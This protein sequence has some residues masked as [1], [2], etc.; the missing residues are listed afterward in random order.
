MRKTKIVC[1]LG[2]ATEKE[3]TI[4]QMML[5]GMNV[6]RLNFSHGTEEQQKKYADTVKKLRKELDL[7]VALMLDTKGPEIRT[8]DFAAPVVLETGSRYT[9]TTRTVPGSKTV[10]S[11][12]FPRLPAEVSRGTRILID[13]GLIELKVE[14]IS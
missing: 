2:P 5:A 3:E 9:L 4:R 1:T 8:G 7:P 13:D 14:S 11:V 10:C 12:S 6:A